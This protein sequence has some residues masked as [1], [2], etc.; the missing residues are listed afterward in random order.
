MVL[1]SYDRAVRSNVPPHVTSTS[2]DG[3][4]V[5]K[6]CS[7]GN[8][9]FLT[10][11][12]ARQWVFYTSNVGECGARLEAMPQ[13]AELYPLELTTEKDPAWR[14]LSEEILKQVPGTN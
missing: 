13:E 6:I 11:D 14:Y 7:P 1:S 8:A 10:F 3:P 4:V 5:R 12:G 9:D 2:V